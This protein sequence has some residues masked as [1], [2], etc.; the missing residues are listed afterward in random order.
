MDV[1]RRNILDLGGHIEI[2]SKMGE[3]TQINIRLPLTLAILDG[4]LIRAAGQT[5][6]MPL[7]SI[8][9][10][11][12]IGSS[13]AATL[14]GAGRVCRFRGEYVPLINLTKRL[15]L[16]G[17]SSGELAVIIERHG[18]V[19]GLVIDDVLGQQQVVIKALED[20]YRSVPGIA[21]ATIMSDG[22]VALILDP[23]SLTAPDKQSAVA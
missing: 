21:G 18:R 19:C 8:I 15:R 22:S 23:P 10:T 9:E 1:V 17:E 20:N 4:Q 3:G 5:F 11:I 12:E 6:V 7:L 2:A 16:A 13:H 14:P